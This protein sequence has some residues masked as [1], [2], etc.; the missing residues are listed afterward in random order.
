MMQEIGGTKWNGRTVC[1]K[2]EGPILFFFIIHYII[3]LWNLLPQDVLKAKS[4]NGLKEKQLEKFM[5]ER[6]T[7]GY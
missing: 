7:M 6:S 4:I 2:Q 3:K 5:E 1:L